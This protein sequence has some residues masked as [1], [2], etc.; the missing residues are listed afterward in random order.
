MARMLSN[1]EMIGLQAEKHDLVLT[2]GFETKEEYVLHLMHSY[3]YKV[4]SEF[5]T[6]KVLD[7]GCNVGYGSAELA[8]SGAE[9]FGVDVSEKAITKARSIA[10]KSG[11]SFSVIDGKKLPFPNAYFDLV[12]S[13]Q[14]IEHIVDVSEYLS[15]I[16]R[17]LTHDGIV[18][19]STPNREIRL[20]KDMKPWN[21]FHVTEYDANGLSQVL[22]PHFVFC[23]VYGLNATAPSYEVEFNRVQ[24]TLQAYRKSLDVNSVISSGRAERPESFKRIRAML[25]GSRPRILPEKVISILSGITSTPH[26]LGSILKR[27]KD[28]KTTPIDFQYY[29]LNHFFYSKEN[30][31]KSLDM[32][33]I[34]SN[35]RIAFK[36]ASQRIINS[37]NL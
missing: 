32:L 34:C 21:S 26:R 4:M 18:I 17:V 11:V 1:E 13:C 33:A 19:F 8:T 3:A 31:Q 14:V 10:Y 28:K 37:R 15:E 9:V 20:D 27:Q 6:G 12:V 23:S 35:S 25:R 36:E 2:D 29:S 24:A 30:L 7:L 16:R 22:S 5:A